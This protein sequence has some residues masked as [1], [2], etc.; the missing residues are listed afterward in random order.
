[1]IQM[2]FEVNTLGN[3]S[4]TVTVNDKIA[5]IGRDVRG[6]V[7]V[8]D[9]ACARMHAVVEYSGNM[10]SVID[11]GSGTYRNGKAVNKA[12]IAVKDEGFVIGNTTVRL[13]EVNFLPD[14]P[15]VTHNPTPA[16]TVTEVHTPEPAYNSEFAVKAGDVI[17]EGLRKFVCSVVASTVRSAREIEAADAKRRNRR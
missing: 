16:P 9:E 17:R 3:P 2:I 13:M 1:M 14:P 12:T 10:V 4:K 7:V 6:Q 15:K 11:L 8:E 5:K